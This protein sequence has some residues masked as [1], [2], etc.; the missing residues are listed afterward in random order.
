MVKK[1]IITQDGL[2]GSEMEIV[3]NYLG[4]LF[5]PELEYFTVRKENGV[6]IPVNIINQRPAG[7]MDEKKII[8]SLNNQIG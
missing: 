7:L 6:L 5:G 1:Y 8:L 2:L 3:P 4:R